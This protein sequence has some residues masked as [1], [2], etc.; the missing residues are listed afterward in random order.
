METR[1]YLLDLFIIYGELLTQNEREYF[2]Y[3]YYEDYSLNEIA[4]NNNVSKSYVG[5]IINK[6][7]K[8]LYDFEKKLGIYKRNN[9]IRKVISNIDDD[10]KTQIEHL[11]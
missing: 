5:K 8:K 10:V 9:D 4:D 2:K 11:L 3:Y 1:E 6:C 7:E